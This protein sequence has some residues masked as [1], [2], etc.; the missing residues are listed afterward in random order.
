MSLSLVTV[1]PSEW[2]T[3]KEQSLIA[4]KSG[5]LPQAIRDINQAL[6]IVL[7]GRELGVPM[8][9][10]LSSITVIKGKPVANAELMAALVYRDH[11]DDA[12]RI[13]KSDNTECVIS[14]KRKTSTGERLTYAFTIEDAR[15]AGLAGSDTWQKYPAAMLRARCISAVCRMAFPDSIAGMYTPEELGAEVEVDAEGVVTIKDVTGEDGEYP[16]STSGNGNFQ[17]PMQVSPGNGNRS[18][19]TRP[20]PQK[21]VPLTEIPLPDEAADGSIPNPLEAEFSEAVPDPDANW[22]KFAKWGRAYLAKIGCA[23]PLNNGLIANLRASMVAHGDLND[24]TTLAAL[25]QTFKGFE[26]S[27]DAAKFNATLE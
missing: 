2:D 7:K 11:G 8:M 21:R 15:K 27:G 10:A 26:T 23:D 24:P 1:P 9:Q 5:F 14:Y 4:L 22:K 25:V 17:M 3:I 19:N 20:S 16:P 18:V 6:A 13:I 12:L